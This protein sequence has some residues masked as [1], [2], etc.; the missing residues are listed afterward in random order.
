MVRNITFENIV[1][2]GGIWTQPFY[3]HIGDS[4]FSKVACSCCSNGSVQDIRFKDI[5]FQYKAA[6]ESS[7]T[8]NA[9]QGGWVSNIEFENITIAGTLIRSASQVGLEVGGGTQGIHF[10]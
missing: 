2:E 10:N 9:S 6:Q 4:P 5:T 7:I 8:G 3:I 1:V